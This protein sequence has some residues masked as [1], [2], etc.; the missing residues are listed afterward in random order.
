MKFIAFLTMFQFILTVPATGATP[1]TTSSQSLEDVGSSI[2]E[3]SNNVSP[4]ILEQ[5]RSS[6]VKIVSETGS[7]GSGTY[8][9]YR[10]QRFILT[11]RHVIDGSQEIFV[12]LTPLVKIPATLVYQSEE[13]DIAILVCE[14]IP[15]KKPIR[16]RERRDTRP[17]LE[18]I[19]SGYPSSHDLLTISGEVAGYEEWGK[20][21]IIMHGYAWPGASGSTIFDSTG[22][23]VGVLIA[24]DVERMPLSPHGAHRIVEDIVWIEPIRDLSIARIVRNF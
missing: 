12:E 9:K 17:G 20:N 4:R 16:Y 18:L 22:R 8:F 5:M 21:K 2:S 13:R 15:G 3:I 19:Y 24:V 6:A 14:E 11:A 7:Y 10:G 1:R 23:V